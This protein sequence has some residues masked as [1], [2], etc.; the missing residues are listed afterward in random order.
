MLRFAKRG[1]NG[2]DLLSTLIFLSSNGFFLGMIYSDALLPAREAI[3]VSLPCTL[4]NFDALLEFCTLFDRSDKFIHSE[5]VLWLAVI[6]AVQ[7]FTSLCIVYQ[8]L[9][10]LV[11]NWDHFCNTPTPWLTLLLVLGKNHVKSY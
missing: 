2:K 9:T 10:I 3:K 1:Q 7:R 8:G 4:K 11:N 5:T 6:V